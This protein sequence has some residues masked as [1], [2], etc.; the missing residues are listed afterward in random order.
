MHD[1]Q[2]PNETAP[3]ERRTNR[4]RKAPPLA[5]M[6]GSL[7]VTDAT[8]LSDEAIREISA[9]L[10]R[11]G[12]QEIEGDFRLLF[13]RFRDASLA[14]LTDPL[15]GLWNRKGLMQKLE[16]KIEGIRDRESG[17]VPRKH[18][19]GDAAVIFIDLDGFKAV[20]DHC[21][22]EVGDAALKEVARRLKDAFRA[23]D[24]IARIGGDEIALM[25]EPYEPCDNFNPEQIAVRVRKALD[26]IVF[27]KNEA[28]Y[29][30]C[31]SIGTMLFDAQSVAEMG[32]RE[33]REIASELL[34]DAD[35]LMYLDKREGKQDRLDAARAQALECRPAA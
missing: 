35:S 27:W 21:G 14:A 8:A 2:K 3:L 20:N 7:G 18:S 13:T 4:S 6:F 26:G 12:A 1:T 11:R 5:L 29:P 10:S 23:D 25:I 22:H 19:H 34:G 30:I 33:A 15:T 32:D 31:A 24:V 16:R 28:P 9:S 17:R